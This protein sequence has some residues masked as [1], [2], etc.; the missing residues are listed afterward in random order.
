MKNFSCYRAIIELVRELPI[1]SMHHKKLLSRPQ[2]Q[3]I[4]VKCEKSQKIGHFD[5][6]NHY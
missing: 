1:S 2:G 6:F 4:D 3:I 5:F